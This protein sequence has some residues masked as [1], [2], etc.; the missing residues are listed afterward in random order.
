MDGA[1]QHDDIKIDVIYSTD[2]IH[3]THFG[4]VRIQRPD[5]DDDSRS[6]CYTTEDAV[7]KA[8]D[9]STPSAR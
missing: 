8:G 3:T 7:I 2:V 1:E 4:S 9:L 5:I 6:P